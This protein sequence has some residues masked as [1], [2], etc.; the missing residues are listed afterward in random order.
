[1]NRIDV[2]VLTGSQALSQL[3]ELAADGQWQRLLDETPQASCFQHPGFVVPWYKSY[4]AHW[5]PVLA[6]GMDADGALAGLWLLARRRGA[7]QQLAHAGAHQAEYHAWLAKPSSEAIFIAA[8]WKAL[9]QIAS[10][11]GLRFKYLP[12]LDRESVL[13]AA[14]GGAG[15]LHVVRHGRPLMQLDADE[16]AKNA[17]KKANKS[18]LNRLKRCG[19]LSFR[20]LETQEEFDT[21]FP[22]LMD[23]YDFRQGGVN[24]TTPFREDE[25]KAEFHRRLFASLGPEHLYASVTLIDG[26]PVAGF[27]GLVSGTTVHLGLL[28]SDAVLAA[29]SPGKLHLMQAAA[30]MC[31]RGLR[32]LDLTPG[33]DAW[34]ERFANAGD[35]VLE[36]N[37]SASRLAVVASAATD[38]VARLAK[39]GLHQVGLSPQQ[40]RKALLIMRK[41]NFDRVS[42]VTRTWMREDREYRIYKLERFQAAGCTPDPEIRR[43]QVRDLLGFHPDESWQDRGAFLGEAG[44][45][46]EN[47]DQVF[48]LS[49]GGRLLHYGWLTLHPKQSVITEVQQSVDLPE[50]CAVLW[51]FYTAHA[52]RGRGAYKRSLNHMLAHAFAEPDIDAVYI[53]VLAANAASRRVIEQAGFVYQGSAFMERRYG[54]NRTWKTLNLGEQ[55]CAS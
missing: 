39:R 4:A 45:R 47:G 8:A 30:D 42:R 41:L 27:F 20:R 54:Q 40:L 26:R 11:D 38:R 9:R 3:E 18:K 13:N 52:Y 21:F 1:M 19:E 7:A 31:E 16:L 23:L 55:A 25:C 6:L 32:T 10:L 50:R 15:A 29:L 12:G 44:R 2:H 5:E 24:G 37:Y 35:E 46:L 22:V 34:K 51:D 17:A 33:G 49:E 14:V 28:I 48:T 53:G 36:V 43:N